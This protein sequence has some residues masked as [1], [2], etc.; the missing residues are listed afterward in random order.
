MWGDAFVQW[1]GVH[2]GVWKGVG[3]WMRGE[4]RGSWMGC[5]VLHAVL[6]CVGVSVYRQEE[7]SSLPCGVI[8]VHEDSDDEE[9]FSGGQKE[10]A[11]EI[12]E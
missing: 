8:H 2:L 3:L 6:S 10:I 5:L 9:D 12:Q 1:L 7:Q 4:W 11:K